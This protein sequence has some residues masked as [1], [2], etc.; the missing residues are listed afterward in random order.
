MAHQPLKKIKKDGTVYRRPPQVEADIEEVLRLA[1][2]AL[3]S[4]AQITDRGDPAYL[5]SEVLTHL[6]RREFRHWRGGKGSEAHMWNLLM[7]LLSR[8]ELILLAKVPDGALPD[9]PGVRQ[10]IIDSLVD[11]FFDDAEGEHPDALDLY[12]CKFNLGFRTLRIDAVRPVQRR[13]AQE[14]P[15]SELASPEETSD[16]D[17]EVFDRISELNTAATQEGEA[18]RDALLEAIEALPDDERKAVILVHVMGYKEESDD[19]AEVTAATRCNCTGRTIRNR[20]KRA[21][22]K[23]AHF[24]SGVDP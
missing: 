2:N 16:P 10:S 15:L 8:C 4:R 1:P 24:S 9:A 12:E 11:K 3:L 17:T 21:A 18:F 6:V 14:I 22:T 7:P 23:L 20:L 13:R 19:P 5:S